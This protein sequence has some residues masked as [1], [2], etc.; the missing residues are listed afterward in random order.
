MAVGKGCTVE[1]SIWSEKRILGLVA[2]KKGGG[3]RRRSY[4]W[5]WT[6]G[7]RWRESRSIPGIIKFIY[8]W[9]L[10]GGNW[11]VNLGW[12]E[13][14]SQRVGWGGPPHPTALGEVHPLKGR[15]VQ[16]EGEGG[17]YGHHVSMA[18]VRSVV[19]DFLVNLWMKED[20]DR[21]Q[22]DEHNR[23]TLLNVMWEKIMYMVSV[24][25]FIFLLLFY[26]MPGHLFHLIFQN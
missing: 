14:F 24:D 22:I 12:P 9:P 20:I 1:V 19:P 11:D 7:G 21:F 8:I 26:S 5:Q 6:P 15:G 2:D 25:L 23:D 13:R 16:V 3:R 17:H 10:L 4:T 18:Q